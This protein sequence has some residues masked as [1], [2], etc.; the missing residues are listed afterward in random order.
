MSRNGLN[1]KGWLIFSLLLLVLASVAFY[2]LQQSP[3]VRADATPVALQDLREQL[4]ADPDSVRGN[5]LRTLN[6]KVQDVQGDIVWNSKQQKGV[7]R[8]V[9]LPKPDPGSFYQL[10]LFDT[11][12]S[13]DEAVLG[14]VLRQGSGREELLVSIKTKQEVPEPYKFELKQAFDDKSQAA[15]ILLMVQP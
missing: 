3:T 14:A 12:K 13:A 2:V 6:P 5:W 15:Q 10:W 11:H 8:I 7:M 9:N 4:L 1:W